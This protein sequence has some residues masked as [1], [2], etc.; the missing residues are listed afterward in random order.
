MLSQKSDITFILITEN[1]PLCI[2]MC[3][4]VLS[5]FSHVR[6]PGKNTGVGCYALLQGIFPTQGLNLCLLCLMHCQEG[7][8]PLV[9]PGKSTYT[10]FL[11][12][13]PLTATYVVCL[14]WRLSITWKCRFLTNVFFFF[15]LDIYPEVG[16]LDHMVVLVLIFW[17]IS[18]L[19]SVMSLP[20]YISTNSAQSRIV[21]TR[22]WRVGE[23][24]KDTKFHL[25][26]SVILCTLLW[27]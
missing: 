12:F 26:E 23:M 11:S 17:G 15:P 14:S 7:S 16:L 8:L 5:P 24:V 10:Y 18:I 4:Y 2:H 27:L 22:H 20:I 3:V 19:L 21:I 25:G 1:I 9:L 6:C 13:H